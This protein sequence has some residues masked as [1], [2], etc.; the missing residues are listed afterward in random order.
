MTAF[1]I[2]CA[3]M[4]AAA[5]LWIT[6]PLLRPK[7][8][9][10]ADTGGQRRI[11]SAVVVLSVSVLAVTMYVSLSEWDWNTVETEAANSAKVEDMLKQLE[12]RLAS[13]PQDVE[14]WLLLGR[15]YTGMGRFA[16]AVDAFQQAYD[17]TK[18]DNIEAIV[19]LGEALALVDEASLTGRAG[20]L[21]DAALKKA[22]THPKALWYGS[23][24][25]KRTRSSATADG[26]ESAARIAGC[27]GASD[28]GPE[29]AA[30][31][32]GAGRGSSP[33]CWCHQ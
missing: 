24:A 16:R 23:M 31:R 29:P 5:L 2:I 19:G 10:S 11:A 28:S 21:F 12:A 18:G 4:L 15:S 27:T 33:G 25:A 17:L 3:V 1:A 13:H 6:L 8:P 7:A 14:G 26:A 32:S 20:Q 22:P 30:R 9:D